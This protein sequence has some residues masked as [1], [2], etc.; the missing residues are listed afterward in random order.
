MDQTHLIKKVLQIVDAEAANYENERG[1]GLSTPEEE[2]AWT[3]DVLEAIKFRPGCTCLDVAAGTGV[4][5]RMLARWVGKEGHIVATDLSGEMLTRNEKGLPPELGGRV[6]FLVGDAHDEKL[7]EST[8]HRSFDY[9]TCR[10]GVVMFANP[11]TVFRHWYSWL[12]Q[13]GHVVVL[14]ALW[15][16]RIWTGPSSELIDHLPLACVQSLATVPYILEQA[17]FVI[18][19][20]R[21]MQRVNQWFASSQ[22]DDFDSPR[23]IV[24]A[25]RPS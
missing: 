10:Q 20:C 11:L 8:A 22:T 17:G 19:Q 14:D 21:F 16:R 13:G 18:E 4:F 5:T 9:I 6:S 23:Y 2:S 7:L 15:S 24:V 1:H 12:N 25:R 3:S